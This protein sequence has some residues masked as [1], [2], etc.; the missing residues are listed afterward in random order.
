MAANNSPLGELFR[1]EEIIARDTE[2][3]IVI[4]FLVIFF[5]SRNTKSGKVLSLCSFN[6]RA[7]LSQY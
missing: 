6:Y 2:Y 3:M 7:Y 5:L 1:V 4:T